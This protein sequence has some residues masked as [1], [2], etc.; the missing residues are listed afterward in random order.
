MNLMLVFIV[1][2]LPLITSTSNEGL[3][4]TSR[5]L[6]RTLQEQLLMHLKGYIHTIYYSAEKKIFTLFIPHLSTHSS[7]IPQKRAYHKNKQLSALW[8]LSW[9]VSDLS[10]FSGQRP[11]E[12]QSCLHKHVGRS[13]VGFQSRWIVTVIHPCSSAKHGAISSSQCC[14]QDHGQGQSQ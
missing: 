8:K 10:Q 11:R 6:K 14:I 7:Y 9:I 13:W 5:E 3:K 2:T 12:R 1:L 4:S